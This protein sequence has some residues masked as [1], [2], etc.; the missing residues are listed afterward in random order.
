MSPEHDPSGPARLLAAVFPG[1]GP[2]GFVAKASTCEVWHADTPAGPVAVRVLAPRAGKPNDI[3][4]DVALRRLLAAS[5]LP[6]ARPLADH[7]THPHVAAAGHRPAWVIDTWIAGEAADA[8]TGHT[9]W[10]ELG[11]L[12][13][14]LHSMPARGHGRLRTAGAQLEG[15]RGDPC[16]GI[17]DRFDEP[18]PFGGRP[19]ADHPLA[20]ADE[21]L[22]PRLQVLE[23]PIR[24]A[25]DAPGAIV[26]GD[27]NGANIRH[28]DGRLAGVIDFAD[29]T[30]L[31]AAWDF[32]SLRH[33]HGPDAVERTLAGYTADR[34]LAE[35]HARDARLLAL[36]IALHHLSRARTLDLP[37][38]R[39]TALDR[40]RRGLDE[41]AAD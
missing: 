33:F 35:R 31:A 32:A 34:A 5:G 8:A 19:L 36:V 3:D 22:V 12:L 16:A 24:A 37:A 9:V 27:L 25:A 41:I 21:D 38:R 28:A 30:V 26:H 29:A 6:V 14:A 4:A 15:R 40:L 7:R 18:W 23:E 13:A 11:R 10:R 39:R 2:P 17:A 20:A 1:A